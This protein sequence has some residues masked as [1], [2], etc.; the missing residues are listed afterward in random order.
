MIAGEDELMLT[1]ELH[2]IK[3]WSSSML[4]TVFVLP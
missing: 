4:P 2:H 1:P 3:R